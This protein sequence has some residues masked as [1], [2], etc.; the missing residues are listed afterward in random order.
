MMGVLGVSTIGSRLQTIAVAHFDSNNYY[1]YFAS[2]D[3]YYSM[4]YHIQYI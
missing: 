1:Y 2:F 4:E 3:E